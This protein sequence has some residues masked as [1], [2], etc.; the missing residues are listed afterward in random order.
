MLISSALET[1]R[2]LNGSEK[3]RREN[4]NNNWMLWSEPVRNS[5]SRLAKGLEIRNE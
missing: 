1:N 3:Q 4:I 5:Y 2:N